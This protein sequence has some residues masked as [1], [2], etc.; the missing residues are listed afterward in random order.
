MSPIAVSVVTGALDFLL[1]VTAAAAAATAYSRETGRAVTA[2]WTVPAIL[3]ATL[4]VGGFE[5]TLK[6]SSVPSSGGRSAKL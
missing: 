3:A 2:T 1:V 4:F 6:Q 5:M